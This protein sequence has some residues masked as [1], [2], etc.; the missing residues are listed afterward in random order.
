MAKKDQKY[1]PVENRVLFE[2]AT[3]TALQICEVNKGLSAL[4]RRLYRQNRVYRVKLDLIGEQPRKVDVFRLKNSFM[5]H[6]GYKL[7]MEEWEKSYRDAKD[8]TRES[9]VGRWRD[10]R[11]DTTA[12]LGDSK[13][14][15]LQLAPQG[16]KVLSG[17]AIIDEWRT[18]L[19]YTTAGVAKDFGL[20]EDSNTYGIIHE[21]AKKGNV[22]PS[23]QTDTGA[24][25]YVDLTADLDDQEVENLQQDGNL[26]PYDAD[27]GMPDAMLE[28]VGTIYTDSDGNSKR[29][30]GFF[31]APLGA[32]YLWGN[33]SNV[34]N[35][36]QAD[37]PTTQTYM[38][39]VV[40][41]KGDY[42]GVAAHEYVDVDSLELE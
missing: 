40:A 37:D 8:V 4:N 17:P 36:Y 14:N 18:S 16:P 38:F 20:R 23:P 22:Q 5:L 39:N 27:N 9:S 26:P 33:G 1:Y 11:I 42:K 29:S 41:Q 13:L 24:A 10:F 30:T 12:F 19:S 7:A 21:W 15:P 32:I 31:D 35:I 34:A 6:Q 2:A 28:Y 25:A 3:G